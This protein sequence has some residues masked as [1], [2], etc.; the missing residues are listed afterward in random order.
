MMNK[1]PSNLTLVCNFLGINNIE[2][3]D[4]QIEPKGNARPCFCGH[5]KFD[6]IRKGKG[7]CDFYDCNCKNYVSINKDVEVK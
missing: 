4:M 3:D 1:M 6:H 7:R 2:K 5:N